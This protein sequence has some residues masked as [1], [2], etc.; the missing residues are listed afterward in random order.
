MRFI[1]DRVLLNTALDTPARLSR[2]NMAGGLFLA[3]I[4]LS[5]WSCAC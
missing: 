4:V 1:V 2:L 5:N 3:V